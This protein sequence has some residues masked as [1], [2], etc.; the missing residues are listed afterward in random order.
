MLN[1]TFN[2]LRLEQH[3]DKTLIG[4]TERGFDF[5]GYHFDLD[6]LSVAKKT[7]E[8]FL[9]VHSGFMSKSRRGLA[10]PPGL[11]C[12]LNVGFGGYGRVS[13][14]GRPTDSTCSRS[15]RSLN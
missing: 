14:F 2:E 13:V 1:Q 12:T 8:N 11:G 10:T 5:L 15:S 6:G 7:V 4:R 9:G 3:P